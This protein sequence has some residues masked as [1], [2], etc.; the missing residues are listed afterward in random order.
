MTL[1]RRRPAQAAGA[2]HPSGPGPL[3]LGEGGTGGAGGSGETSDLGTQR[4]D[5]L[6][7]GKLRAEACTGGE[8]PR[9]GLGFEPGLSP[10]LFPAA[11]PLCPMAHQ[12]NWDRSQG[13]RWAGGRGLEIPR[14]P[15]ESHHSG[16]R[17][18]FFTAWWPESPKAT[19]E[20]GR[21]WGLG[22]CCGLLWVKAGHSARR[23]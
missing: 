17:H 11:F 1:L 15:Q 14:P 18:S 13:G 3:R 22:H 16:T 10:L 20:T 19:M 4:G 2:V 7:G 21:L 23:E 12:Q 5:G 6:E 8:A 9:A